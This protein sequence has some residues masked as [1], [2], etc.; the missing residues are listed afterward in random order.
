MQHARHQ[1]ATTTH[2]LE[3][4][5]E[6]DRSVKRAPLSTRLPPS[7]CPDSAEC[8]THRRVQGQVR[9]AVRGKLGW[10]R[11]GAA[12]PCRCTPFHPSWHAALR[13]ASTAGQHAPRPGSESHPAGDFAKGRG[14]PGKLCSAVTAT[15]CGKHHIFLPR[16]WLHAGQ[17]AAA[18]RSLHGA[19]TGKGAA[20]GA[21]C[22]RCRFAATCVAA[23]ATDAGH[24]ACLL[25]HDTWS[26]RVDSCRSTSSAQLLIGCVECFGCRL[27]MRSCMP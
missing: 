5:W 14:L 24:A 27:P 2:H 12:P 4:A 20:A 19:P 8:R 17:S 25:R 16:P 26:D 7:A 6:V 15:N 18:G 11:I 22:L 23:W 1:L 13:P 9:S 10:A 21:D 3:A